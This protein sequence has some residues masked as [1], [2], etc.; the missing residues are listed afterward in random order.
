VAYGTLMREMIKPCSC[1][2]WKYDYTTRIKAK[3]YVVRNCDFFFCFVKEMYCT[4]STFIVYKVVF[5]LQARCGPE[6]G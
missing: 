4:D 5:L 2:T 1:K 3:Y 6:G